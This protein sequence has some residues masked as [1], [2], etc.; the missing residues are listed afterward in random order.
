VA[1][2]RQDRDVRLVEPR[3]QLHVAEYVRVAGDVDGQAVLELEHEADRLARVGAVRR[4]RRVLRVGERDLDAVPVDGAALVG[5]EAL[6]LL[7]ALLGD[8]PVVELHRG[9]HV[10]A[11]LLV[12]RH[13]V[14]EVVAVP[15]GDEDRVGRQ[16]VGRRRRFR[17]AGQERVDQHVRA[18][19]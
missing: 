14:A 17:V 2:D 1:A 15:V 8:E 5:V 7:D 3:D 16:L 19:T 13:R 11:E 4:G 18:A 6:A 9:E 10:A 12:Q